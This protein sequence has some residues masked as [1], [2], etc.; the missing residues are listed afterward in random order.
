MVTLNLNINHFAGSFL[1]P[2]PSLLGHT[3]QLSECS[4]NS[5][6][7]SYSHQSH[8]DTE[9][10]YSTLLQIDMP[11][12]RKVKRSAAVEAESSATASETLGATSTKTARGRKSGGLEVMLE[13]PVDIIQIVRRCFVTRVPWKRAYVCEDNITPAPQGPPQPV[14][15]V[16]IAPPVLH[17]KGLCVHVERIFPKSTLEAASPRRDH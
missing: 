3:T 8:R 13:M 15:V 2:S 16:E 10:R 14:V 1:P 7:S 11:P 5:S 4:G 6:L 17:A 12:R 9:S